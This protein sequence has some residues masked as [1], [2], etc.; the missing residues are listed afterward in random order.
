MDDLLPTARHLSLA[1]LLLLA[2]PVSV[3]AQEGDELPP[4]IPIQHFFDNPEIAGAQISPNGQFVSFLKPYKDKLNVYVRE[5]G[6]SEERRM[7]TDTIRPVRGY[8]WSA[9][10]SMLLYVQDKGGNENYHVH[11]VPIEGSGTP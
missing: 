4:I 8:F 7:T 1:L 11:S 2:V 10:G 6:S 9:D 5:I 3:R